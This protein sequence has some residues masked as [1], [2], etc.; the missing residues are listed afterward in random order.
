M[1]TELPENGWTT[2]PKLG[3]T[4]PV[5]DG[6][7]DIGDWGVIAYQMGID[8]EDAQ[9]LV[10]DIHQAADLAA[11]YPLGVT[12]MRITTAGSSS[13][14]WGSVAGT[15]L[16]IITADR[17]AAY[18]F[19]FNGGS[20]PNASWRV[21]TAS[22]WSIWFTVASSSTPSA[23]ATGQITLTPP[24]GGGPVVGTVMLPAG[25]TS[26]PRVA[27]TAVT[28]APGNVRVSLNAS[29]TASQFQVAL[30]RTDGAFGTSIQ[31]TATQG[32]DT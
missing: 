8:I 7:T 14:G 21:N 13:G 15:I 12:I 18:Q 16:T 29:P 4:V 1:S 9:F 17:V 3:L 10:N 23:M 27:L 24:S 6:S 2:K 25:F 22:G 30:D 20:N 32:V 28:G 11:T 31:W 26:P 5:P 19:W